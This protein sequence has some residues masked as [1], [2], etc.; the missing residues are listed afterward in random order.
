M[1][2]SGNRRRGREKEKALAGKETAR[3]GNRRWV[4]E[5]EKALAGKET[6]KRGTGRGTRRK[7]QKCNQMIIYSG[8]D[9]LPMC[10]PVE[11]GQDFI[12]ITG[13]T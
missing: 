7:R 4:R 2:R 5:K 6:G 8:Q 12:R 9:L 13:N 3:P 1:A 10:A 11:S